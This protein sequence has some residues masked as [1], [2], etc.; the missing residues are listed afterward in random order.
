MLSVVA[1][2]L[3]HAERI[4]ILG[5]TDSVGPSGPNHAMALARAVAVR[6]HL[7]SMV[8]ALPDDIRVDAR[9]LC[10]YAAPNDT[11]EG[12]AQNRRVEVVFTVSAAVLP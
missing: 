3:G 11:A 8:P 2:A 9:G 5:R 10:C 7:R 1:A 6:N 4:L 12:R